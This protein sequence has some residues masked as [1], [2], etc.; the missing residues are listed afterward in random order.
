MTTTMRIVNLV[1]KLKLQNFFF[2]K[3]NKAVLVLG[4]FNVARLE[5]KIDKL[6]KTKGKAYVPNDFEKECLKELDF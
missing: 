1:D 5:E 4:E 3:D 6:F 2:E